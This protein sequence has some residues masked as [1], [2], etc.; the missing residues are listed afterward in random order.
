MNRE[1]RSKFVKAYSTVLTNSWADEKYLSNLKVNP[2]RVLA[3]AGLP[4]PSGVKITVHTQKEGEG[5]LED[6]IRLWESG[7]QSGS[8]DLYVP[9]TPQIKEGELSSEQLEAIAG[10][11]DCCCCSCTPCCTCT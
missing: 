6:Q 11:T 10:G 8:I 5:T 4:V 2:T 7:M 1:S 3:D 9:Q